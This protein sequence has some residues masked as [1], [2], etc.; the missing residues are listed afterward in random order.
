MNK[1]LLLLRGLNL[2]Y[3]ATSAVLTPF[4]PIYF[5]GKGYSTSQI[6]LLMMFGPFIAIFAQPLWG[7]LSDRYRTLKTII[8][9]LWALSLLS[10][11]GVFLTNGFSSAFLFMLLLY[12]FLLPAVPLL[13]SITI[14]SSLEAGVS[15]GSVRMFGSIGFTIVAVSSGYILV[16]MGGVQN[17]PYLYWGIWL[18]PLVLVLFLKDEK[19]GGP[20]LTFRALGSVLRNGPFLW[21]LFMVFVLM[22]PHRM[23]DGLAALYLKDLGATDTMLG[24][25]WAL[26]SLSEIP[27]FALL[28][29]YMHR[30]HELAMLGI[31]GLIYTVR[32]LLYYSVQDPLVVMLLQASHMVTFAVFWLVAVQY[33]VRMVPE[34]LRST[35]QSILSA[36]FLG[37]AGVTGGTLGGMIKDHWG[38]EHMYSAGAAMALLAAVMFFATHAYQRNK[39]TIRTG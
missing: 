11:A 33:A 12:F 17:I 3:Y 4:L 5:E 36:V 32:W 9:A 7:Y 39:K 26:A 15:Y 20:R 14:K 38:G 30:F 34:E 31:V 19:G 1:Q 27:T 35:G 23:N 16:R 24:T 28:G 13:D 22:V 10:S 37:L 29:R 18:L 21:F 6:G 2:L 25:A 8:F